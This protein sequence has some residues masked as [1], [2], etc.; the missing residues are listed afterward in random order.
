LW[1]NPV[2]IKKVSRIILG[3]TNPL[4]MAADEIIDQADE[5]AGALS[6]ALMDAKQKDVDTETA[7]TKQG[8]EWFT[9]CRKLAE[10]VKDLETKARKMSKPT[11]KISQ[12]KDRV[13]RVAKEVGRHTIGLDSMEL[14]VDNR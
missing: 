13:L 6:A 2:E 8:I 9:R 10:E 4:E 11:N 14:R 5:I 7:L 12:A 3:H 1:T